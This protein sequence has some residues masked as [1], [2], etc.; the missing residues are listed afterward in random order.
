MRKTE[1]LLTLAI[2]TAGITASCG[3]PGDQAARSFLKQSVPIEKALQKT[4]FQPAERAALELVDSVVKYA[5]GVYGISLG[6]KTFPVLLSDRL[7]LSWRVLSIPLNSVTPALERFFVDESQAKEELERANAADARGI[8][9]EHDSLSWSGIYPSPFLLAYSSWPYEVI[10]EW[11]FRQL[12]ESVIARKQAPTKTDG[13]TAFLTEKATVE[14]L[15]KRLTPSS[16]IVSTYTSAKR[17]ERTFATLYEDY[18]AQLAQLYGKNPYPTDVSER[19]NRLEKTW[20]AFYRN[21]YAERFL[22]HR[23]AKADVEWASDIAVASWVNDYLHWKEWDTRF[24]EA[25]LDLV[26]FIS[27][28]LRG[29]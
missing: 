14:F 20:F 3:T 21:S 16:P 26:G 22:T 23:Y 12:F 17:D 6:K 10:V 9:L 24:R 1:R 2:L 15:S 19:R 25:K 27:K 7:Q 18:R 8:I 13:L 29:R 5:E 11:T 28:Y 4:G